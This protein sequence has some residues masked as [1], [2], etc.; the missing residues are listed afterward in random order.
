[1]PSTEYIVRMGG[2]T[3][4]LG[5]AEPHAVREF[6]NRDLEWLIHRQIYIEKI[7]VVQLDY[8][9]MAQYAGRFK[10]IPSIVFEHDVYFQSIARALPNMRGS[11]AKVAGSLGILA[12]PPL[13]I[14]TNFPTPTEFRSAAA[15]TA[16]IWSRFSPNCA[17]ASTTDSGPASTPVPT[18][19]P[20][21]AA[22]PPLC[23][24]W[25]VFVTYPIRK[26]WHGSWRKSSRVS[27]KA[28]RMRG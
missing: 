28:A 10:Q 2:Q 24:S 19:T 23:C 7:D 1:M 17:A 9:V 13:R 11:I 20:A 5:A 25:A 21:R 3:K 12:R 27:T 8:T 15:R 18:S 14:E 4:S 26:R 16:S 6:R 22:N